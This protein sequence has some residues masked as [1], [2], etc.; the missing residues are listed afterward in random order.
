VFGDDAGVLSGMKLVGV[1]IWTSDKGHLFVTLPAKP[2]K[3]GRYFDY[4]RPAK[5]GNGTAKAL[6]GAILREWEAMQAAAA[7]VA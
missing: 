5:P 1:R 7:S 6:K 3:S 2:G 4:L